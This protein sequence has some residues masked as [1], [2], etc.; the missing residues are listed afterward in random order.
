MKRLCLVLLAGASLAACDALPIDLDV[1]IP[2]GEYVEVGTKLFLDDGNVFEGVAGVYLQRIFE[3]EGEDRVR[4]EVF[5]DW[6]PESGTVRGTY[7]VDG[8]ELRITVTASSS[9]FYDVGED[10]FYDEVASGTLDVRFDTTGDRFLGPGLVLVQ[11]DRD[12]NDVDGDGDRLEDVTI[13]T[14]LLLADR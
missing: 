2:E 4:I 9:A 7:T 3:F 6:K 5:S 8:D 1:D 13:E 10:I 11:E 12:L 14:Y